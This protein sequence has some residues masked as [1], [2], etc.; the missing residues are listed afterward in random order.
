MSLRNA[1][2]GNDRSIEF[3]DLDGDGDLDLFVGS[4]TSANTVWLN[5][6]GVDGDERAYDGVW[7]LVTPLPSGEKFKFAY[8]QDGTPHKW[9]N[10]DIPEGRDFRSP[11]LNQR[12]FLPIETF[13]RKTH[14]T[15]AWHADP[16]VYKQLADSIAK[17]IVPYLERT[18]ENQPS[19]RPRVFAPS[20]Q[21]FSQ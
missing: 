15:D 6:D 10:L 12:K 13:G 21:R 19:K 3:G 2:N 20:S 17:V 5:D 11:P 14:Q 9:E 1:G 16:V 4:Y 7:S 8:T 18:G